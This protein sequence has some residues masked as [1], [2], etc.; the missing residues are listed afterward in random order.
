MKLFFPKDQLDLT[1]RN[2]IFPLLKPFLKGNDFTNEQRIQI[3]GASD[4]DFIFV[5]G[6][7]SANYVV[8]PMSWNYYV[9]KNKEQI[10]IEFVHYAN[11][12]NKKVLVLNS[13]DYGV[14][15]PNFKNALVF[16]QSGMASKLPSYHMGLPVFIKDPLVRFYNG[17]KNIIKSYNIKPIVGFC[18]QVN[19]SKLNAIK[20][21]LKVLYKNMKFFI[22][23]TATMPQPIQSSSYLR[24]KFLN[25]LRHSSLLESNFIFR[26]KH[27]AGIDFHR[28]ASKVTKEFF[29][30]IKN[31]DYILCYRGAGNFSVRF[32]ETLAM[33][34]IPVFIDS[35]CL[36]P[37]SNS[38]DWQK[39]MVWIA[40]HERHK[41]AEKVAAFHNNLNEQSYDALIKGNRELWHKKFQIGGFFKN[42]L[43][44]LQRYESK[45]LANE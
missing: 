34:R 13:G 28:S 40:P 10:A 23:L 2:H 30:N 6:I 7:D 36:L 37:L 3:Y 11:S 20:E 38:I 39:H 21:A 32:Y 19:G 35:D 45:S 41:I 12:F 31:S 17:D 33:G 22:K 44:D 14:V 4:K 1:K 29:E 43:Q 16:R 25:H 24:F 26:K 5:E 42:V 8:L 27:G 15:V 9:M 18:G